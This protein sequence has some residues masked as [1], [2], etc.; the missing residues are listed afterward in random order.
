MVECCTLP[1]RACMTYA[2]VLRKAC[3]CVV[4]IGRAVEICQMARHTCGR[5]SDEQ[6]AFV[7]LGTRSNIDMSAGQGE[8]RIAMVKRC[9]WP[10]GCSVTQSAVLRETCGHV[11]WTGCAVEICKMA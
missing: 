6:I 10:A 5:E 9:A 1:R 4:W 8:R 11:V 3:S 2:A 7:T